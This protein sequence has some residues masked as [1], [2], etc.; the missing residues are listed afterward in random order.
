MG[1]DWG[2][3]RIGVSVSDSGGTVATPHT[4]LER[5]GDEDTDCKALAAVAGQLGVGRIVLGLPLSLNGRVG[6][7]AAAMGEHARALEK[8]SG[9][10][11]ELQ[12]ERLSTVAASRAQAGVR[13]RSKR[14]SRPVVDDAAAALILQAWLD[15]NRVHQA[16]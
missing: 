7:A 5:S 16:E 11:V 10:T 13:A 4:V 2:A 14:R 1:V 9:L 12:D 15:A 8:A 6:P 3:R